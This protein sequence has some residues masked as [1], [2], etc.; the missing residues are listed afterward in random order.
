MAE[1]WKPITSCSKYEVSNRGRVRKETEILEQTISPAGFPQVQLAESLKE[2]HQLV[3][4][5]F[6]APPIG[7]TGVRHIDGNPNKNH[8]SNLEWIFTTRK[9]AKLNEDEVNQIRELWQGGVKQAAIA[10]MYGITQQN[11]NLIVNG[12]T[13]KKTTLK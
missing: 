6:L 13:W 8:C 1:I 3:A 9:K 11:V 5:H 10:S 2:V 12:Y 4:D 7:A